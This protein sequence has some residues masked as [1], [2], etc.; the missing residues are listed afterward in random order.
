MQPLTI[1]LRVRDKHAAELSRQARAVNFV[2]NYCNDAQKH[3][4]QTRRA[5][6]DKWLSCSALAAATAG[7][8]DELGLHSHTIQRVCREYEKSRKQKKKR[9]LRYR[10]GKSLGLVPFNTGHVSFDG[11]TFIFRGVQYT[12][13]HLQDTLKP[14]IKIGAGSFNQDA[15]G[16]WY[17]SPNTRVGIDLG[18]DTLAGLSDGCEIAPPRFYRKSEEKLA[19]A[20]R[21]NKTPKRIRNIHVKIAN[22]RKDFLHKQSARIVKEYGLV[23]V[24]N[25]NPSRL[26]KTNM[27]KSVRDAGWAGFKHMLSYKETTHGGMCLEVN[28]AYS[29]RICSECGALSGP[30]GIADLGIRDWSYSEYG[31][32][33]RRDTNSDKVLLRVGLHTLV[34]GTNG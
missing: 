25:V 22:R 34:G 33:H 10:R 8:A 24:G 6:R 27:A 30:K 31:A 19:T 29:T 11:K 20:Q 21:A 16:R 14:G 32:V 1:K 18:L 15:G 23:V 12:T 7:V 2:W 13:T 9:G 4:F 28:E 5:W 3:A 26:A 17:I